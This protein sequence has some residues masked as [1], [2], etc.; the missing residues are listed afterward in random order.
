M[1]V[2][3]ELHIVHVPLLAGTRVRVSSAHV[4]NSCWELGDWSYFAT[5]KW[6]RTSEPSP[7]IPLAL[8]S[9]RHLTTGLTRDL[10]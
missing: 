2:A 7:E 3:L 5:G 10:S 4:A 1:R 9:L 6:W 8:A